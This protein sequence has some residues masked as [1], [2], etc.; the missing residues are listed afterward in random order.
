MKLSS[1]SVLLFVG[2]ASLNVFAAERGDDE[3]GDPCS[4][5]TAAYAKVAVETCGELP[6]SCEELVAFQSCVRDLFTT[7]LA[8]ID[9]N[10]QKGILQMG[11]DAVQMG[12]YTRCAK[13]KRVEL[14]CKGAAG[15]EKKN[16]IKAALGL[17]GA[18]TDAIDEESAHA[19]GGSGGATSTPT[20]N[21]A[22]PLTPTPPLVSGRPGTSVSLP[23]IRPSS[24]PPKSGFY[25]EIYKNLQGVDPNL[26]SMDIYGTATSQSPVLVYIHGGG[27]QVGDKSRIHAK[28]KLA[29]ELGAV[30][31]SL[32]YRLTPAV[33][34]PAHIQDIAAALRWIKDNI[35]QYGGDPGNISV[36]GHSAGAQ[37]ASL[38]GVHA[39]YLAEVGL[40]PSDVRCAVNIDGPMDLA[41]RITDSQ[42]ESNTEAILQAFGSD[43][44][45][46]KDASPVAHI[47]ELKGKGP[48]FLV[49]ARG[50]SARYVEAQNFV[51][52]YNAAQAS[53]RGDSEFLDGKPYSHEE[54]NKKIGDDTKITPRV[55]DFL[56]RC[57]R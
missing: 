13:Q 23:S 42:T 56:R 45:T 26:I 50:K 12:P 20:P 6:S 10:D 49:I 57:M 27:W 25:Q 11:A 16:K 51:N 22:S 32:N 4:K 1:S 33:R 31:V 43:L 2:L 52:Q 29:N 18:E 44:A 35:S 55:E 17:Q 28:P 24:P 36:M 53:S 9:E 47:S 19:N 39:G 46:L 40:T 21:D 3:K 7:K 38:I 37:L 48:R 5:P 34:H 30:L 15:K 54:V 8:E 14:A 41:S